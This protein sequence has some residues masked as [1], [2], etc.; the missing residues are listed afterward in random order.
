MPQCM[1]IGKHY[2]IGYICW[3]YPQFADEVSLLEYYRSHIDMV[4]DAIFYSI[5]MWKT[6]KVPRDVRNIL[7]R[8]VWSNRADWE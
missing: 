1:V 4:K 2:E 7:A 6:F 3:R 8:M 5:L